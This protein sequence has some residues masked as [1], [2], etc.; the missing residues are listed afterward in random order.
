[1]AQAEKSFTRKAVESLALK[2]ILFIAG[3]AG[4][5]VLAWYTANSAWLH[6]VPGYKIGLIVAAVF[7]PCCIG[8]YFLILSIARIPLRNAPTGSLLEPQESWLAAIAEQDRLELHTAV[9]VTGCTVRE[10]L[11]GDNPYVVFEFFIRNGSV[12]AVTVDPSIKGF[13]SLNSR[14]LLGEITASRLPH[15]LEHK[16]GDYFH[17][18]QELSAQDIAEIKILDK[19]SAGQGVYDFGHLHIGIKGNSPTL[20]TLPDRLQFKRV[21]RRQ[22]SNGFDLI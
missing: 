14:R 16:Y 8:I 15:N 7:A 21:T 17:I 18:R 10:L 9:H 6:G 19:A 11:E 5:A 2:L 4:A 22:I 1:M 20:E 13:I 12:F 3:L